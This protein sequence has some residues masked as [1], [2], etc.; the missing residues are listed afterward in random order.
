MPMKLPPDTVVEPLEDSI[1][2]QMYAQTG[3]HAANSQIYIPDTAREEV[4]FAKV[5]AVGPGRMIDV[6][7][8]G[9][10]IRKPS[11]VEVG[12][13]IVFA[14]FHGER[15]EIDGSM[16]VV[17]RQGD[18]LAKVRVPEGS[19]FFRLSKAGEVRDEDLLAALDRT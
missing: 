18:V 9:H 10:A 13:S 17:M 4:F 8:D 19:D 16:Y 2:C 6:D 7:P 1:Y 11:N 5:L 14:R 12:D 3:R 15:M